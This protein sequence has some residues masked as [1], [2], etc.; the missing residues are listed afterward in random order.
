MRV[1]QK[2]EQVASRRLR[3]S[4]LSLAHFDVLMHVGASEGLTQQE[5]A[6]SLLVTKGNVCPGSR[7]D[8]GG[9]RSYRDAVT[10]GERIAC[11]SLIEGGRCSIRQDLPTKRGWHNVFAS[12]SDR[13]QHELLRLLRRLDQNLADFEDFPSGLAA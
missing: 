4:D 5:V 3:C 2:I 9:V 1:F 11:S 13:E 12:L 8:G 6:D 10:R 7:P